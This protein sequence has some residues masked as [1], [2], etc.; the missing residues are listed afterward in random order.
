MRTFLIIGFLVFSTTI[1]CQKKAKSFDY[2]LI[3]KNYP[4]YSYSKVE[5]VQKENK[6]NS[7]KIRVLEG[8]FL[9]ETP[10]L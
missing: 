5:S 4:S 9:T 7:V 8:K 2:K 1:F 10:K 6:V 3:L